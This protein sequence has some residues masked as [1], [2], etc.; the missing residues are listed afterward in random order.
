MALGCTLRQVRPWAEPWSADPLPGTYYVRLS[1]IDLP[2]PDLGQPIDVD[3][4][5]ARR[6][7]GRSARR[8]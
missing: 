1:V 8:R 4:L 2:E 5:V 6:R 3:L 7:R